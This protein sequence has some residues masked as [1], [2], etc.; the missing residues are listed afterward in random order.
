MR[1][2]E[3]V[4]PLSEDEFDT[5]DPTSYFLDPEGLSPDD[6]DYDFSEIGEESPLADPD[7][8]AHLFQKIDLDPFEDDYADN[9][10]SYMPDIIIDEFG[11][12][13]I[14]REDNLFKYYGNSHQGKG[15]SPHA[16]AVDEVA[17][18]LRAVG[19]YLAE[20]LM[21]KMPAPGQFPTMAELPQLNRGMFM[22]SI[23]VEDKAL[24]ARLA[25]ICVSTPYWGVIPLAEFFLSKA[26]EG[27]R[28]AMDLVL[29]NLKAENPADP[30]KNDYLWQVVE[31]TLS[32][33]YTNNRQFRNILRNQGIPLRKP[34]KEI[35]D[36]VVR[37]AETNRPTEI[38]LSEIPG[39]FDQ[40]LRDGLFDEG[41]GSICREIQY[42]PFVEERIRAV[43]V[44]RGVKV[45]EE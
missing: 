9:M 1:M 4:L 17:R 22:K 43:L 13:S 38:K 10:P 6:D 19:E 8:P 35:Y 45:I 32:K 36:S 11:A 26:E 24:S 12:V 5:A 40:L 39:I 25:A 34:R 20:K 18:L 44:H 14:P 27:W 42:R 7:H 29:E 30:F 41:Q 15:L 2:R 31:P 3:E 33:D 21:S 16:R 23:G 28:Q 37:W